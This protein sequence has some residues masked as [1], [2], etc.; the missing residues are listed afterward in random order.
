MSET[1]EPVVE[2]QS[3][4]EEIANSKRKREEEKPG[5]KFAAF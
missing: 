4:A 5:K 2:I 3:S 1:T